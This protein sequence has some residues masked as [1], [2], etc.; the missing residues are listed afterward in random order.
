[1]A[2]PGELTLVIAQHL[3]VDSQYVERV[4]AWDML[5]ERFWSENIPRRKRPGAPPPN[6]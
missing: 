1:L 6:G 3:E 5:M 2:E 4:E